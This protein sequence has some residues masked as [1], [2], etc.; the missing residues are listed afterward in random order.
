MATTSVNEMHWVQNNEN[1]YVE[2]EVLDDSYEEEIIEEEGNI[3]DIMDSKDANLSN[4][5][6]PFERSHRHPFDEVDDGADQP[7]PTSA[8]QISM[9]KILSGPRGIDPPGTKP[10]YD[11]EQV[12]KSPDPEPGQPSYDL[13]HS[14]SCQ[15]STMA[16]IQR[17]IMLPEEDP[18]EVPSRPSRLDRDYIQNSVLM[19]PLELTSS[20]NESKDQHVGIASTAESS[21]VCIDDDKSFL[22]DKEESSGVPDENAIVAFIAHEVDEHGNSNEKSSSSTKD[23]ESWWSWRE[24]L[25]LIFFLALTIGALL[26]VLFFVLINDDSTTSSDDVPSS[27]PNRTVFIGEISTTPLDPYVPNTCDHSNQTQ[28]HVL[29]QC[30]C[31]GQI[32]TLSDNTKS[33]YD[34]LKVNFIVPKIFPV[35]KHPIDSCDPAN[36]ALVWLATG[37]AEN[38]QEL[39]QRYILAYL[40]F[41]LDGTQW[42]RQDSWLSEHSICGW[43]GLGCTTGSDDLKY[44]ELEENALRGTLITELGLLK[45]LQELSFPKNILSGS[46]PSEVFSLSNLDILDFSRNRLTGSI[47]TEIGLIGTEL[48]LLRLNNNLLEGSIPSEIGACL[49]LQQLDLSYNKFRGSLPREL[50]RLTALSFLSIENNNNVTGTIPTEWGKFT[51]LQFLSLSQ[52]AITGSAPSEVCSLREDQLQIFTTDCLSEGDAGNQVGVFCPIPSCCTSCS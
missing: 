50:N 42:A 38:E 25:L 41:V 51:N 33:K 14:K 17:P 27:A 22:T 47:P 36:Q 39:L 31:S 12:P 13:T 11:K 28:P 37:Y 9:G 7:Q 43:H 34:Q 30:F 6:P 32:S 3:A 40:Y 10:F 18:E 19:L 4:D 48:E 49:I 5:R 52:T 20:S 15:P 21:E 2:E 1:E 44:I 8:S 46:I 29:S 24:S 35:W 16:T 23:V 26:V 45:T